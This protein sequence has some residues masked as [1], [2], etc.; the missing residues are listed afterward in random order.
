M[1][2]VFVCGY[3][4]IKYP[5]AK[6]AAACAREDRAEESMIFPD[7]FGWHEQ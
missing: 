1:P 5:D 6:S 3:C 7:D 2:T 4:G